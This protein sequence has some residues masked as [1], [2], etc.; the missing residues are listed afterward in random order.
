MLLQSHA[1][2]L[3]LLPALPQTWP[4]GSVK[5]LRARGGY[6]VDLE[7][8]DGQVTHYRIA[9]TKPSEVRVRVNGELKTIRSKKL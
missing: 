7:W 3:E 5:G 4:N 1:G 6:T 8:Q 2:E 9:S